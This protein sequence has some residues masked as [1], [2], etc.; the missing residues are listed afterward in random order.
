MKKIGIFTLLILWMIAIFFFSSENGEQSKKRSIDVVSNSINK[1]KEMITKDSSTN[2]VI[3]DKKSITTNNGNSINRFNISNSSNTKIDNNKNKIES[4][5][6]LIRKSAH[7]VEYFVLGILCISLILAY[8][9]KLSWKAVLF[10]IFSCVLYACFD[11][12]HQLFVPGRAGRVFDV[13]VDSIGISIGCLF[14]SFIWVL[15][16]KKKRFI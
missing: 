4:H 9:N 13:F 12:V 3:S 1:I 6:L 5:L 7:V 16:N 8:K 2:D 10:S 15:Y 11:E 14:Y